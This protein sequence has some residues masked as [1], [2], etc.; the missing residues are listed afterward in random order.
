MGDM[1]RHGGVAH[2]KHQQQLQ[3]AQQQNGRAR[4]V[5]EHD[6]NGKSPASTT[7]ACGKILGLLVQTASR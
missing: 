1:A 7:S 4:P 6:A 2:G 5:A 3:N